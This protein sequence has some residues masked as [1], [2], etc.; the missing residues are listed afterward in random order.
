MSGAVAD[1]DTA[2]VKDCEIVI[3]AGALNR[4]DECNID[5]H[6]LGVDGYDIKIVGQ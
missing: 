5:I 1:N 3:G 4:G 6:E 2:A